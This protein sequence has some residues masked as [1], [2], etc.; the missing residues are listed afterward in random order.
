MG[1]GN[2]M[3]LGYEMGLG[4]GYRLLGWGPGFWILNGFRVWNGFGE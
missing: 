2:E 4:L 1:L 3:G